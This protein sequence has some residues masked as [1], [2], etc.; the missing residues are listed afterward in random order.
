[1]DNQKSSNQSIESI[2]K[3]KKVPITTILLVMII[4]GMGI[5]IMY[6]KGIIFSDAEVQDKK[7]NNKKDIV[8]K[9]K[10]DSEE[11]NSLEIKP[12]DI[13]KCLNNTTNKYSNYTDIE[14]NY[15]L[16]TKINPDKKSVTLSINWNTFGPLSTAS[17][18]SSEVI[19][20][21][22]TGFSK[23]INQ[24]FIGDVGQ[25]AMGITIFYVMD[26]QTVE[27]TPMFVRK[28]DSQNNTYYEMNYRYQKG[29]DGKITGTYFAT[30]ATLADAKNVVK[31]YSADASNGSGWR[32]TIGATKD[33]SFYDLGAMIPQ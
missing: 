10:Q 14:G 32:T 31:L 30:N 18:Y 15:G 2:N 25:D 23:E 13:S 19:D 1:M 6:D 27:Y 8:E 28:T 5:Y 12:L 26:D 3:K 11:N 21:Q 33:G 24:V 29:A 9:K 22:I 20:Y 4:L 16:S 7:S 17:S